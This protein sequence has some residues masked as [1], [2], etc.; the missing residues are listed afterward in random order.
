SLW[1]GLEFIELCRKVL[2]DVKI[3]YT[4]HEY[5]AMCYAQGQLFRYHERAI[6]HQVA[7]DQCVK[8][9]PARSVEEFT[10]RKRFFQRAFSRVDHFVSPSAYLAERFIEWGIPREKMSVIANG[11]RTSRPAEWH[12]EHSKKLN[13]FGYFGQFVDAKG[14]D[15]LLQAARVVAE[16]S[17]S[18][19]EVKIFGGNKSHASPDYLLRI[20][21]ALE[22]A[23][24]N[25]R[26][27]EMGAYSREN[28]FDLMNSVDWVVVPSVW[29]ETFGLVVS[30]AWEARRPILAS[31]AG[32]LI[33]RIKHG[34]NGLSF[35]PGSVSGLA[36]LMAECIGNTQLWN[37]ISGHVADE[38]SL[39]LA[40]SRHVELAHAL[41]ATA[42]AGPQMTLAG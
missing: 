16:G 36:Q 25:L 42:Q 1:V 9:F 38:I 35:A 33:E 28:V 17:N 7:P 14:I 24:A 31:R 20:E 6:C 29:P 5:L 11:H 22:N 27:T 40:W 21:K 12:P 26:V 23:P 2:P 41:V 19:V 37:S 3:I 30:E 8:C 10:L 18:P 13:V 39:D 15:V 4:L 32:G 34:E